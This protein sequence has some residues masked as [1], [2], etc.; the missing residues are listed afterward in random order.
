MHAQT[1]YNVLFLCK[2]TY[3][4]LRLSP[5]SQRPGPRPVLAE[6]FVELFNQYETDLEAVIELYEGGKDSPPMLRNAPPVRRLSNS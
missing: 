4:S 1:I 3:L 5:I 2:L 6:K